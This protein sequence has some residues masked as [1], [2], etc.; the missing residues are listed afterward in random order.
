MPCK[1]YISWWGTALFPHFLSCETESRC[2]GLL[3]AGVLKFQQAD[4]YLLWLRGPSCSEAAA[5]S[6][7]SHLSL[8]LRLWLCAFIE[9][10]RA[11]WPQGKLTW[12]HGGGWSTQTILALKWIAVQ[13]AFLD[14]IALDCGTLTALSISLFDKPCYLKDYMLSWGKKDVGSS[15]FVAVWFGQS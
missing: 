7:S 2:W 9:I 3:C 14:V 8:N 5:M 15:V 4:I 11:R 10:A 12:P 1:T 13:G 6:W